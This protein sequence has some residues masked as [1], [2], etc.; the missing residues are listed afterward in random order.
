MA[1]KRK[2]NEKI[3]VGIWGLGRAGIGMH[4]KEFKAFEKEFEVVAGCDVDPARLDALRE[5]VPGAAG[6]LDGD[7]FLADPNME[8]V[9]VAVRSTQHVDYAIRALKAGKYVVAEKPLALT[10]RGASRLA[11]ESAKHP[12]RLLVRHNRRFEAAF[13]HVA[14]I[15]RGGV[16]GDVYE[17][18][19]CRHG[20]QGL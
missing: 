6:Y 13:N 2:R 17:I 15:V 3:R 12:G 5:R 20:R 14:E 18:K 16:L 8:L 10:L 7:E 19:L 11:R 4:L 9:A 1:I